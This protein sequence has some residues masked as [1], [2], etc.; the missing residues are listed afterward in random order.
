MQL[1]NVHAELVALF[2][3]PSSPSLDECVEARSELVHATAQIIK[4]KVD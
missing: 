1:S 3:N 2:E 4:A